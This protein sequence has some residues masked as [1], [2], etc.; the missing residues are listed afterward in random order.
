[1]A[2][3][4]ALDLQVHIYSYILATLVTVEPGK[5]LRSTDKYALA[6]LTFGSPGTPICHMNIDHI[7]QGRRQQTPLISTIDRLW[8]SC[9]QLITGAGTTMSSK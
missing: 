1:M 3:L 4:N 2:V 6:Y 7:L 5:L 9:N 8:A